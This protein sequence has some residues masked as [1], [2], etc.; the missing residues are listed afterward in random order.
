M[1]QSSAHE[2]NLLVGGKELQSVSPEYAQGRQEHRHTFSRKLIPSGVSMGK[3]LFFSFL[4][5]VLSNK[6]YIRK[7][8]KI[9][10]SNGLQ[11]L[12]VLKYN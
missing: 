6:R 9:Y 11:N 5:N 3:K 12:L 7:Q 1:I 2:A 10:K 8:T 4:S